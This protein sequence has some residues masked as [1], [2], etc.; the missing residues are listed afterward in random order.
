M[1]IVIDFQTVYRFTNQ[2]CFQPEMNDRKRST[3]LKVFFT[4]LILSKTVSGNFY[5]LSGAFARIQ[6][7]NFLKKKIIKNSPI[8][9][10]YCIVGNVLAKFQL[11]RFKPCCKWT[12]I[13]IQFNQFKLSKIRSNMTLLLRVLT[14]QFW[15]SHFDII[16]IA[17][18]KNLV[19][20]LLYT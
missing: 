19:C 15:I 4:Q 6:S 2:V 10:F 3:S 14:E 8:W 1:N 11:K 17:R 16:L 18:T 5:Y 13:M 7:H 12:T 20:L 9:Y